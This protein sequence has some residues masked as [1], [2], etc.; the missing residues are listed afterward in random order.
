MFDLKYIFGHLE[1]I[2][3]PTIFLTFMSEKYSF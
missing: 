1:K 3:E 2:V